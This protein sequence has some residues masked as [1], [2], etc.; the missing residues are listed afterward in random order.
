MTNELE[1]IASGEGDLTKRIEMK[2]DNEIKQMADAF[3]KFI[4]SIKQLVSQIKN[5]AG[6]VDQVSVQSRSVS[7]EV[8]E[9]SKP[10]AIHGASRNRF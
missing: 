7:S 5:N 6:E 9:I 8:Q 10:V 4:E 3:N 1:N 2:G